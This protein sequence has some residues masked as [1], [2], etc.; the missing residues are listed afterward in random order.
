MEA[1]RSS[2]NRGNRRGP[3][4]IKRPLE[5]IR[6]ELKRRLFGVLHRRP[7]SLDNRDDH[8]ND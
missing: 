3:V 4:K 1:E 7:P 5:S 2:G 6:D 8:E